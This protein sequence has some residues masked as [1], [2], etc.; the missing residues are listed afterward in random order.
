MPP[1]INPHNASRGI[2][3]QAHRLHIPE[4]LQQR[5]LLRTTPQRL[6]LSLL[7]DASN[8]PRVVGPNHG[9]PEPVVQRTLPNGILEQGKFESTHF[10]KQTILTEGLRQHP[11]GRCLIG[12]FRLDD[13]NDNP[14]QDG[15]ILCKTQF[16]T[17]SGNWHHLSKGIHS[18]TSY[19]G[20]QLLETGILRTKNTWQVGEFDSNLHLGHHLLHG[21]IIYADGHCVDVL[22]GEPVN[23][24]GPLY[25]AALESS[26]L[27]RGL[28]NLRQKP[29]APLQYHKDRFIQRMEL[30]GQGDTKC[31]L[32]F[33]VRQL[34]PVV[35]AATDKQDL[36]ARMIEV[37]HA[38]E[39]LVL[40]PV[41]LDRNTVKC[42]VNL[43][44]YF[45]NLGGTGQRV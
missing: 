37:T 39:P 22:F 23:E 45:T 13:P 2:H 1:N 12:S 25:Q 27:A 19:A 42:Y 41:V 6:A 30:L 24:K 33:A 14:L 3:S 40:A 17:P 43:I 9:M 20:I 28:A 36:L 8:G 31:D 35:Q 5:Y 32:G 44:L 10:L 4:W 15:I 29:D 34:M 7:A 11:D 21:T 26:P 38:L 18:D 16:N